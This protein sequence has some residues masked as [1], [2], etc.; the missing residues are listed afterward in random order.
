MAPSVSDAEHGQVPASLVTDI[1][2]GDIIQFDLLQPC[3]SVYQTENCLFA[4]GSLQKVRAAVMTAA[5]L[6]QL[7]ENQGEALL[8]NHYR[9]LALN[10]IDKVNRSLVL[11]KPDEVQPYFTTPYN[12]K[13]RIKFKLGSSSYDLPMTDVNFFDT[14]QARLESLQGQS[15]FITISL[16]MPFEG[17][18]YKLAAGVIYCQ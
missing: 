13:P 15:A 17:R 9:S 8:G 14:M 2:V 18:H 1:S 3:P 4:T 7:V 12:T 16:G 5:H 6:E 10:E 11:I